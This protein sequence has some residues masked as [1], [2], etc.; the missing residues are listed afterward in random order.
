MMRFA[1]PTYSLGQSLREKD[2]E[3]I[4]PYEMALFDEIFRNFRIKVKE[5]LGRRFKPSNKGKMIDLRR[6]I[7]QSTQRGGEIMQILTKQ[8]KPRE[9]KLVLLADVS[10]SMDI[11]SRFLIKFTYSLQKYLR[12]TETFVFGTQLMR[13]SDILSNRTL[14]SAMTILSK[15]VQFWSGGT[16][17]GGCF[18]EFNKHYGG[19]LRKRN[20]ILVVL[21]DGWDKGDADLLKKQM[22]L[23]KRGFRKIIWLNPNLKYDRYEPLCLGMST[24]MPYVDHFLPCHNLKTLEQFIELRETYLKGILYGLIRFMKIHA[25]GEALRALRN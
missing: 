4:A 24:A 17:I 18:A 11:Y 3:L 6:S 8:R 2:F 7:R 16:D 22:V 15:K 10:G 5:K 13:I 19:K 25:P 21:S 14:E 1:V 9:S 12:D 20:R 23:F